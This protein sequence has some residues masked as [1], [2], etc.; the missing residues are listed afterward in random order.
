MNKTVRDPPASFRLAAKRSPELAY[1]LEPF[2][3][4]NAVLGK[5]QFEFPK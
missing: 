2:D 1:G 4:P 3:A 5:Y